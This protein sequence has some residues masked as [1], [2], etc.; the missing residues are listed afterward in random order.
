MKNVLFCLADSSSCAKAIVTTS[1]KMSPEKFFF[2]PTNMVKKANHSWGQWHHHPPITNHFYFNAMWQQGNP[3]IWP[4]PANLH[5]DARSWPI[6]NKIPLYLKKNLGL[7]I[8]FT[9]WHHV[10]ELS[11]MYCL[12]VRPFSYTFF[13][14]RTLSVCTSVLLFK[15]TCCLPQHKILQLC[16][17]VTV[18]FA[19]KFKNG[20]HRNKWL[21]SR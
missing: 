1:A 6:P 20:L 21:C 18:A 16:S 17:H 15:H 8:S 12:Y 11:R 7:H 2:V 14:L 9:I 19:S 3:I 10:W 5:W 4:I 13:N